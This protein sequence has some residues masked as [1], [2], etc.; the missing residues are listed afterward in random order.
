MSPFGESLAG[1]ESMIREGDFVLVNRMSYLFFKPKVG[2]VVVVR[3]PK[4]QN[5]LLLKRIVAQ[6]NG[7]YWIEGD[8]AL[9]SIDSRN[10]G[11]VGREHIVG[12]AYIV[13][14]PRT[15]AKLGAGLRLQGSLELSTR[16]AL[17]LLV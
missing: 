3:H 16:Q 11:W 1:R 4:K 13:G 17:V 6:R 7:L 8:N 9:K 2:H 5:L 15:R 10:F 12:K 14:K